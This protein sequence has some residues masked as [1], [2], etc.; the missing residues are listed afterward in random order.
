MMTRS[1]AV[2]LLLILVGSGL[3]FAN[4][5]NR[6][7]WDDEAE[8]ALLARNILSFGVPKATDG[9]NL[10]SQQC[11]FDY[12]PT[13]LWR[14][15]P[16]LPMYV[17]ALSFKIFGV[18]TF[19]AR[20]PFALLGILC[21]PS[22]YLL[23]RS[24]FRERGVAFLA[25]GLL[26]SCVPFLLYVR[27]CRYY[28]LAI[29]STI[30]ILYFFFAL[31]ESKRYATIGL[32][33]SLSILFHSNF[34]IFFAVVAGLILGYLLLFFERKTFLR[35]LGALGITALLTLPFT[36]IY[37]V[38]GRSQS[39]LSSISLSNYTAHILACFLKLDLYVF[40]L[41]GVLIA[42]AFFIK[43]PKL[44]EEYPYLKKLLFLMVFLSVGILIVSFIPF[45]FFR[46][47]TYLIPV[48]MIFLAYL[49]HRVWL[50]HGS[51]AIVLTFIILFTHW[52]Y[53][54]TVH[55]SKN[56]ERFKKSHTFLFFNYVDEI[57]HDFDG[58]FEAL[59]KFLNREAKPTDRVFISHGDL[60]LQFYTPLQIKG[61]LSCQDLNDW[62]SLPDWIILRHFF[63]MSPPLEEARL[64][65]ER[66]RDYLKMIPLSEYQKIKLDVVDTVWESI[67]EPEVHLYR[68]SIDGPPLIVY[69]KIRK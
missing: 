28:A 63:R 21:L 40:P 53:G 60:P 37:D 51:S 1:R 65:E 9:Q 47:L 42:G 36:G 39:S 41:V 52:L 24:I 33:L 50:R 59:T 4:L 16:W 55:F 49:L 27:Q 54:W 61:G 25:V 3:I 26:M 68:T 57:T 67:P 17:T 32:A 48:C 64:D 14:M 46:Y 2:L 43:A 10:I 11:G 15:H 22:I 12:G 13:Y 69:K 7:L 18:N 20:L 62:R 23:A 5:S 6:Y 45:L 38:F 35:L 31:R 66:T 58:P 56:S 8:T 44:S 29:L 19:S 34:L 30:W